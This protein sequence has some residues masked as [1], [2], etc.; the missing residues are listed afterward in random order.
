VALSTAGFGKKLLL[1][2]L[3]DAAFGAATA[4][5]RSSLLAGAARF[6]M[7]FP[8]SLILAALWNATERNTTRS[9]NG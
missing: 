7:G 9:G 6:L 5:W 4:I 8:M 3:V 2:V 1:F